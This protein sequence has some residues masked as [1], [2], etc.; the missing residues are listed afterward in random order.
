MT[1]TVAPAA[2]FTVNWPPRNPPS[3]ANVSPSAVVSENVCLNES[4][5]KARAPSVLPRVSVA[6]NFVLRKFPFIAHT[7]LPSGVGPSNIESEGVIES[8]CGVR[9]ELPRPLVRA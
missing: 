6:S 9:Y 4:V 5:G 1:S 2:S 8:T 3:A 7:A